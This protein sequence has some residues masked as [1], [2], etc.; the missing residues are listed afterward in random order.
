MIAAETR[1]TAL[2]NL[3]VVL[4]LLRD[5]G[6]TINLSKCKFLMRKTNY[7]GFEISSDGIQP[8]DGKIVSLIQFPTP[9][10]VRTTRS[11]LGLASYFRR[12][13][14]NFAIIARPLTDL[15]AKNSKFIWSDEQEKAFVDIKTVLSKSPVLKVYNPKA[16]TEL[17]TDASSVGIGCVLL[18]QQTDEKL[19]PIA[20]Y[21]RKTTKEESKYPS[22][23]IE[24]LAI[25]CS[26]EKFR[27]YLLGIPFTIRTDCN[28]LKQIE[29]KRDMSPRI[30][31]WFVRLA[32]YD[33]TIEY[34]KGS[35]NKV[36]DALSRNPISSN[37]GIVMGIS[38]NTDWV[39]C[40][41][42]N[43]P[44][45]EDIRKSLENGEVHNKFVLYKSR[46]YRSSKERWRLYVPTELQI[47]LIGE[48]HKEMAHQG[49]DKTLGRL[50][51]NY[52]FPKMR[53]EVGKFIRRCINCLYYK[54]PTG[55]QAG[56]LHPLDKGNEPFVT[57]HADH[58]GPFPVTN[59]KRKYVFS[60]V[61]GFSKY[62]W[63]RAVRS[64][65]ARESINAFMEFMFSYGRPKRIITDRGTSFTAKA[66]EDMCATYNIVHV[67]VAS[68]TPRA[69]GQVEVINT[70]ILT[71][72][73]TLSTG[74][75]CVDWD[76]VL[77]N[78]QWS[79]NNSVHRVTKFT[80]SDIVF[81]HKPLGPAENPLTEE[82]RNV[83][84]E[85]G[86]INEL[87]LQRIA[88]MIVTDQNKQKEYYDK[89]RRA[90]EQLEPGELVMVRTNPVST[91]TSL[92]L[93]TKYN[94]PYVV[95]KVLDRDRYI[96]KDI[97]GEQQTGR[98]FE[99]CVA[100]DKIKRI[101]K[102]KSSI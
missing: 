71:G 21:S 76:K 16:I 64:T 22:I 29:G 31:R 33:Y 95:D 47:D 46:V 72:L 13:V 66:Y 11:F 2:H 38:I 42:R 50:K 85:V 79:I 94:G 3:R 84:V 68:H 24:A 25:V 97:P 48:A 62:V 78:V 86:K 81:R 6:L 82:I 34:V 74:V 91:G 9:H 41:Q 56:L 19:Y 12:F 53:D 59:D 18:Q 67:K 83:N 15:L 58:L 4:E 8:G 99:A 36:A 51:E 70:T 40:M 45:I 73:R 44:Q 100:I 7:L 10:D 39:A 89:K 49:V 32:E 80:P 102:S 65:E 69:N 17:H 55:K 88:D 52:Y 28:S 57:V 30:A 54:V 96:V 93:Q 43:C 5:S 90:A 98:K 75:E 77:L 61:D 101:P 20:Y 60:V 23:E 1:E 26:L 92:K 87:N 37:D 14:K 35:V 63:L 27:V